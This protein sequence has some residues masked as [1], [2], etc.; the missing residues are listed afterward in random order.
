MQLGAPCAWLPS[1]GPCGTALVCQSPSGGSGRCAAIPLQ[2]SPAWQV[3]GRRERRAAEGLVPRCC[4]AGEL[5]MT[6]QRQSWK[7]GPP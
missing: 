2:V 7:W 6:C 1:M 3:E 5:R 4:A